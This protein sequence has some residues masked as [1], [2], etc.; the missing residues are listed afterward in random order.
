MPDYPALATAIMDACAHSCGMPLAQALVKQSLDDFQVTEDLGFAADG[1]GSHAFLWVE[2]RDL[3]TADVAMTLARFA[4]VKPVAV[5]YS[6]LKD[7]Q[8]VTRQWFSIDL[9]NRA[10]PPWVD[11]D[12]PQLKIL[13]A[14]RHRRKLRRGSHKANTFHIVLQQVTGDAE[15]ITQR[16]EAIS[17]D[18]VPN[19]FER[20]RF[21]RQGNNLLQA[22]RLFDQ[23]QPKR[24]DKNGIYLSAARSFLF[25][26]VL[27]ERVTNGCWN[28]AVAGDAM[29][30]AGTNSWFQAP[31]IN[32]ELNSRVHQW[33]IHPSGPMW[34]VGA[35][36]VSGVTLQM[37]QDVIQQHPMLSAGLEKF[38][39]QHERRS[40]RLPVGDFRWQWPAAGTLTLDFTLPPGSFATA[41][42]RELVRF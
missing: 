21:G 6:G 32:D 19:Y 24:N 33:D 20:Q 28:R 36:P 3:N 42:V 22:L 27:N 2:K 26:A 11:L 9:G 10:D 1:E 8:A 40:L 31:E 12:S 23:A 18:G 25:N 41:V 17:R 30:L 15:E 38:A 29:M 34:G 13:T 7:R 37:E 14:T 5:G 16:L 4:R 35:P 39:L